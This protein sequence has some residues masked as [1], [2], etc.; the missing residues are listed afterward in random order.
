MDV[1]LKSMKARGICR[2]C[3]N[4]VEI[5]KTAIGLTNIKCGNVETTV[6]F[7]LDC[8]EFVATQLVDLLVKERTKED[9]TMRRRGISL[10]AAQRRYDNMDNC[11]EHISDYFD[12]DDVD[13]FFKDE[14][15]NVDWEALQ[16]HMISE[17][18]GHE[19][20]NLYQRRKEG[21]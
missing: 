11:S 7:C 14:D 8:A 20:E 6:H 13:D 4:P 5:G 2:G 21:Y 15:G 17:A 10:E 12:E 9:S 18:I 3:T 1:I 19:S 16:Q